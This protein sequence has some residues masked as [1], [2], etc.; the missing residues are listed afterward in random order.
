[1]PRSML[2]GIEGKDLRPLQELGST[3]EGKAVRRHDSWTVPRRILGMIADG[4]HAEI[5]T[6]AYSRLVSSVSTRYSDDLGGALK[7]TE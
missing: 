1:M 4:T 3:C 2:S 5:R 6:V 7:Y